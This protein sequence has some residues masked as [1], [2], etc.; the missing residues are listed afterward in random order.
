MRRI[1]EDTLRL[2]K[3]GPQVKLEVRRDR[4]EYRSV[5]RYAR[6]QNGVNLTRTAQIV[7]NKEPIQ[8]PTT[9][10]C[11]H[12]WCHDMGYDRPPD[13][14]VGWFLVEIGA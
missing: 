11:G 1:G 3:G 12:I 10:M 7:A 4:K 8:G 6:V 13:Q 5:I 9:S 14:H 2:T